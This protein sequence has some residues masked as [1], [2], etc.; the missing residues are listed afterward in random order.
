MHYAATAAIETLGPDDTRLAIASGQHLST[1]AFSE[2]GSRS[3]FWT[4]LGTATAIAAEL[5][6]LNAGKSWVTSA[7][8]ADSYVWSSKVVSS[9]GPM[10]LWLVPSDAPGLEMTGEFDGL[11]LRGNASRP[12]AANGVV[13]PASAQLGD[14]GAG[15]DIALTVVLPWVLV[16]SAAFSVGIM[17]AVTAETIGH[18]TATQLQH[19]GQTLAQQPTV[20]LDVAQMQ[21]TT[22]S[23]HA[24][25]T[26][27]LEAAETGR[28]D[29][30]LRVLG[31]RRG[32]IPTRA[33]CRTKVPRRA[34][35]AS[36]GPDH[37]RIA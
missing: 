26:D 11:G 14:D 5:V 2:V 33:R 32:G 27:T 6:E 31:L 9:D 20:R 34:R 21:I 13:V 15:L 12:V 30:T 24:L 23:A 3:H 7:G 1:L 18:V 28:E 37:R 10:T 36:D 19:L 22:D 25:V 16:C 4:P 35:R 8:E 29:A 17:R